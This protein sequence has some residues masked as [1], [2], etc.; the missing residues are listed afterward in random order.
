M[1]IKLP[2]LAHPDHFFKLTAGSDNIRFKSRTDGVLTAISYSVNGAAYTDVT[3][4]PSK[5]SDDWYHFAFW[6]SSGVM[7]CA[8]HHHNTNTTIGSYS[9]D[10]SSCTIELGDL[11]TGTTAYI[12]MDDV[13]VKSASQ[14]TTSYTGSPGAEEVAGTDHVF[15]M[16]G[17]TT[18]QSQLVQSSVITTDAPV[19][20]QVTGLPKL[21]SDDDGNIVEQTP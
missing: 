11:G 7:Y 8:F 13:A 1:W 5:P 21:V 15:L 20:F 4:P 10:L 17:T 6:R 12:V 2:N 16:N 18:Q 9:W 19:V 3:S 14:Y